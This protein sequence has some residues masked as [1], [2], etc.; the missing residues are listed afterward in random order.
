M[1]AWL[2][3]KL[4]ARTK[5]PRPRLLVWDGDRADPEPVILP[6]PARLT[7]FA[8]PH[9]GPLPDGPALRLYTTEAP[10]AEPEPEPEAGA[11]D[12]AA[13]RERVLRLYYDGTGV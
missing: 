9:Q 6:F 2:R 3:R 1:L 4:F 13:F 10:E 11:G 5:P 8:N 7:D 12:V